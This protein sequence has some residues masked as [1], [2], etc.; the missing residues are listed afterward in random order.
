MYLRNYI[1]INRYVIFYESNDF[2]KIWRVIVEVAWEA[3]DERWYDIIIF[4]KIRCCVQ[5]ISKTIWIYK[6]LI[7][8]KVVDFEILGNTCIYSFG[9][10]MWFSLGRLPK[11]KWRKKNSRTFCCL[12]KKDTCVALFVAQAI[13]VNFDN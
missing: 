2:I 11:L 13:V 3:T 4:S 1:A 5:R 10:T 6:T 7:Y 8:S 9:G 12:E